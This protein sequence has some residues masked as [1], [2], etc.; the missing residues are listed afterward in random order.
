MSLNQFKKQLRS[1]QTDAESTLWY[2]LRAKIF[3]DFKFKRQ[4]IIG[5]YIVDF[6]CYEKRLIIEL[7]VCPTWLLKFF[8]NNFLSFF[9]HNKNYFCA[10]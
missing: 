5:P 8:Q 10:I 7:G 9:R 6:V 1:N 2:F 3:G 4:E